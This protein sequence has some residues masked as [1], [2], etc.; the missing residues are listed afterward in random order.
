V[1]VEPLRQQ[2]AKN[3]VGVRLRAS[4]TTLA[5]NTRGVIFGSSALAGFHSQ[6]NVA[7]LI[8][9]GD[10]TRLNGVV[11]VAKWFG[12]A[13]HN[14]EL[15]RWLWW[16]AYA[17]LE[18]DRF[19]RVN[20]RKL[21]GTGPRVCIFQSDALELF[22]GLSYMY[23]QTALETADRQPTGEGSAHRLSNYVALTLRAHERI[24][25]SSVSYFQPRINQ[26]SD[27]RVL[28][29][30][31]AD[32]SVTSLLH[33]R[34]DVSVRYDSATPSDVRREDVELKSSLEVAF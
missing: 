13:R 12:H 27:S 14:Y 23:E 17:Q 4:A 33:S 3:G 21:L 25:L 8:L 29:V 6:R 30:T 5:G 16:E 19:R 26:P 1:N 18:S 11:S 32:F 34:I 20:L 15:R 9:A 22:Y 7:Y 28:S 31:G 10:Y 2:V 24:S